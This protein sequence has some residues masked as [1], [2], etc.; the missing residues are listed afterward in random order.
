MKNLLSFTIPLALAAAVAAPVI[1]QTG[2]IPQNQQR[3]PAGLESFP[4]R[5]ACEQLTAAPGG[6]PDW[7]AW[8]PTVGGKHQTWRGVKVAT[9]AN[10]IYSQLAAVGLCVEGG[11]IVPLSIA[12]GSATAAAMPSG[13]SAEDTRSILDRNLEELRSPIDNPAE[14][15]EG[16]GVFFFVV[17][18]AGGFYLYDK[19]TTKKE[20][21]RIN[22]LSRPADSDR[23][24]RPRPEGFGA[25]NI[26]DR[27]SPEDLV[28]VQLGQR[29]RSAVPVKKRTALEVLCASPFVSRAFYGFQRSGKTNL[30][31][32]A[33]KALKN[34]RGIDTFV[35]N[36]SSFGDEDA[37][38]WQDMRGV[39]G[40]LVSINDEAEAIALVEKAA[41][42]VDEFM[43]HPTP[44]ILVCDEWTFI[45]AKHGSHAKTLAPLV[46][47]LANKITGFS[48][49]GMKR[50]K[51]LWAIS[52]T[53]VAGELED[54]A[55]SIKK[56][57]PC[58]VAIAP[59]HSEQW[60]GD[61]LTFSREL[62][63]QVSTNYPGA[64]AEPPEGSDTSRI[65]CINGEWL[66][67]GTKALVTASVGRSGEVVD[68]LP[69]PV[70]S[71]PKPLPLSPELELFHVWLNKK[72]GEVI[73]YDSFNNANCFKKIS[74]SKE[75]YLKLC[76]K[77]IIKGW[78]SQQGEETFFV[79]E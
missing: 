14:E 36:L 22:G 75:S 51:A 37:A 2:S 29:P 12:D 40:D 32:N 47:D 28:S 59:G 3:S 60:E 46:S 15:G 71:F 55:K 45:G 49:S 72:P 77:A 57:S 6:S 19:Y 56:L 68:T 62:F 73:D 58:L 64:L 10:K 1:A 48:S 66:A 31:A 27:I 69:A 17:L 79:L 18:F 9:P 42:L 70:D 41:A 11:V 4:Y 21:E 33:A 78:L 35:I 25:T 5:P 7:L 39:F 24:P 8:G 26:P 76:D 53:I 13:E 61:E 16:S 63:S 54:F 38:Y 34:S 20:E 52:P 65:A 30:V 43:N 50:R 74:R 67:L 44:A 23:Q